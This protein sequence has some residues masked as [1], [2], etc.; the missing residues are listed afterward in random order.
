MAFTSSSFGK[1]LL[2]THKI[3][4]NEG[5]NNNRKKIFSSNGAGSR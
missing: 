4:R 5:S 2:V 1:F 3:Y